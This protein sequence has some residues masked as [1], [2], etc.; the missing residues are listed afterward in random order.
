MTVSTIEILRSVSSDQGVFKTLGAVELHRKESGEISYSVGNSAVIFRAHL[1]GKW[2]LMKCYTSS[3]PYRKQIYG[4]KLLQSEL[5]IHS[6]SGGKWIDILLEEWIEGC[7]LTEAL[8][9]RVTSPAHLSEDF[10]KLALKLLGEEWAHGDITCDNI[11]LDEQGE[12]HPIDFDATFLPQFAGLQSVELGTQAFQHP[13]RT[14]E[15][16]DRSMDDFSLALISTA[17]SAMAHHAEFY[18]RYSR[19]EGLLYDPYEIITQQS[20]A[21]DATLELFS[22]VGDPFSYLIAKMLCSQNP[23]LPDLHKILRCKVEGIDLAAQPSTIFSH[24]TRWGYLNEFG[25][26]VIPPLFDSALN[27]SEGVAAV[28]IGSTWHYID[29]QAKVIFNGYGYTA[30]KSCKGGTGRGLREGQWCEIKIS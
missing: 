24:N 15:L 7:T 20:A 14:I 23:T 28:K 12:L 30:L 1:N 10:D 3:S 25:R 29:S 6:A 13:A 19:S 27:F 5:Y 8:S 16:F 11:I 9:R 22:K 21:Y 4:D 2:H 17:L 26:E 18:E